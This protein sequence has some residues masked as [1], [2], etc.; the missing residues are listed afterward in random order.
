MVWCDLLLNTHWY[1]AT[2]CLVPLCLTLSNIRW[3]SRV[4][5]SNPGKR[6]VPSTTRPCCSY[7]KR[8][9]WG[10]L[11]YGRQLYLL[12][13]MIFFSPKVILQFC[14]TLSNIRWGSRVKW[15]NPGKGVAP[16]PTTRC[17]SYWKRSL[18]VTLDYGRQLYF[19]LTL[20]D[21]FVINCILNT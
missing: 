17:S 18:L 3:W 12:I 14:L 8:S 20:Y 19:L 11:D 21:I 4:K 16:S 9:L 13:Y 5:W 1:D 6:V 10:A 7:W 2:F 15:S